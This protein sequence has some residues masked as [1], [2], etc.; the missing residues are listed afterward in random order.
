M[1]L[2]AVDLEMNQ[3]S[4]KIIQV[5]AVCFQPDQGT[6]IE[7]FDRFVDPKEP[8]A[9]EIVTL[10]GISD[11]DV[12]NKPSIAEISDEFSSFKQRLQINPIGIVWGA[13]ISNDIRKI[14]EE[15][16][17]ETPFKSRV[18]DVKAVF[19]MLANVSGSKMR[20]KVGLA[21]ACELLSLGWD[22][23]FGQ[24]HNALADAYNTMRVYMFLSKC[25]KG[26]VDIKL[27]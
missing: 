27:G 2:V 15:A 26:A 8:I 24:L 7:T 11:D 22:A 1:R 21:K 3:P 19:Q 18:I 12:R 13:G 20:Q 9:A 16:G 14:Y 4:N 10:T 17:T 25:L 23:K 5:G 6:I